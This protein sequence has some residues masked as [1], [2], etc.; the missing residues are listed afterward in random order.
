MKNLNIYIIGLLLLVTITQLKG[1]DPQFSQFYSSPLNLSPSLAGADEFSRIIANYR[2]QWANLPEA[3]KTYS[4]SFDHFI[5]DYKSGIGVMVLR[6]Q[7]G[8]VYNTTTVG[9]AYSY[10]IEVN[11][12]IKVRPGL[13]ATYY[14]RSVQ[15]S[16]LDFADELSRGSSSS[17]E[18]PKNE[19]V[20]HYDFAFS[21]LTY[22]DNYWIGATGDHL[23]ALNKQF[24][25]DP[26]Y[27]SL[28]VMLYGGGRFKLYENVRSRTDKFI[29]VSFLYK[30][31]AGFNQVDIGANYE[32]E[33]FRI[34]IWFRGIPAFGQT[35]DLN[36]V[37]LLVGYTFKDIL[38]NYSYDISTSRLLASTGGAHEVSIAYRLD[39]GKNKRKYK[40]GAVPC[41]YF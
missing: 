22:T 37:V 31:Q 30:N 6:D 34:G 24:A 21:L 39:F 26:T 12:N 25:N 35:A 23:L 1:Q 19:Q 14:N 32:K 11:H 8:G 29:S 27:P 40:M 28:K 13:Q 36:A 17:I 16:N 5:S 18:I 4:F 2:N 38:I 20:N 9:L 33:P 41:P 7:E 10:V 3:Y 15:Y